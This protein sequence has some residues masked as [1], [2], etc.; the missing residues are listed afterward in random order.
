MDTCTGAWK[1]TASAVLTG[2][3]MDDAM[4]ATATD[5]LNKLAGVM[6]FVTVA[7][8]AYGI[9]RA[10]AVQD[11]GAVVSAAARTALAWPLTVLCITLAVKGT[12]LATTMTKSI[13]SSSSLGGNVPGIN[14]DSL[15]VFDSALMTITLCLC[16]VLGSFVL[17]LMMAAR[18]F[19][20]I[21]AIVIAAIPIML[22]GWSTMRPLV[23][24]WAGWI[25]GIIL[26]QPV[27]ALCIWVT[28]KLM[29][30]SGS[31]TTTLI[32]VVGMILSS[33][34]PFTLIRQ[35][36]DFIPGTLGLMRSGAAGAATVGA[37][38]AIAGAAASMGIQGAAGL[39]G[40]ASKASEHGQ[41]QGKS[42]SSGAG[43]SASGADPMST[44][45]GSPASDLKNANTGGEAG[46]GM[47]SSKDGAAKPS[48][49]A[50]SNGESTSAAASSSDD[51][52][53]AFS[54]DKILGVAGSALAGSGFP[55]AGANVSALGDLYKNTRSNGTGSSSGQ[56]GG[57]DDSAA[58]S[59]PV[60]PSDGNGAA[61][62]S[63]TTPSMQEQSVPDKAVDSLA[64][65]T[66]AANETEKAGASD[67]MN[68]VPA[69]ASS[70]LG[71]TTPSGNQSN[72]PVSDSM[73]TAAAMPS[74]SE[75][76]VSMSSVPSGAVDALAG[77]SA[78]AAMSG[79]PSSG[80]PAAPAGSAG[81]AKG[82][83]P[84]G[85]TQPTQTP[86]T[87]NASVPSSAVD[88]LGMSP[89]PQPVQASAGSMPAHAAAMA[90]SD[91]TVQ[92]Q[93]QSVTASQANAATPNGPAAAMPNTPSS[94]PAN[95]TASES[96][97][98]TPV[99]GMFPPSA[100][101]PSASATQT[102]NPRVPGGPGQAQ[103]RA[104]QPTGSASAGENGVPSAAAMP[105]G[106]GAPVPAA[107][108]AA[109][110]TGM[111][112][113]SSPTSANVSDSRPST[114]RPAG[115][116]QAQPQQVQASQTV[117]QP[118]MAPAPASPTGQ[119]PVAAAAPAPQRQSDAIQSVELPL[120]VRNT[121]SVLPTD[122]PG[123]IKADIGAG[124]SIKITRRGS[125]RNQR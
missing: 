47:S 22:Q 38:A 30:V 90:M 116:G 28:C 18:N 31:T 104:S 81:P 106:S 14:K 99:T 48:E 44:Q 45:G 97:V 20:L 67:S 65:E 15:D 39:T 117:R 76:S 107:A 115:P 2:S 112:P 35:I 80:S 55:R 88:A 93:R 79:V 1:Y 105:A 49:N 10:A 6:A 53:D 51:D 101:Q 71:T 94:E 59:S 124:R 114:A 91:G 33:I 56:K 42:E 26:M 8:G 23:S 43:K 122:K 34:F 100:S 12:A 111:V 37:A 46:N 70:A 63:T 87:V 27:M 89:V 83:Q 64:P 21:F 24:K 69:A 123:D 86:S 85:S 40:L 54:P 95:R 82:A 7:A 75:G 41:G 98:S 17:L 11:I 57:T 74:S 125:H 19:L 29:V 108:Q 77:S 16:I 4:W 119:P 84:T 120:T 68:S 36:A 102:T 121:D 60:N 73:Q 78:P 25:A 92:N 103:Q 3:G 66:T 61:G 5:G 9:L 72:A 50:A 96:M 32:A 58:S 113:P 62:S 52:S 110:M 13:L 118:P 109:T